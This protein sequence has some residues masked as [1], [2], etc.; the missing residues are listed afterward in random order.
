MFVGQ[1]DSKGI[2]WGTLRCLY[3]RPSPQEAAEGGGGPQANE[4]KFEASFFKAQWTERS[5][6]TNVVLLP[7]RNQGAEEAR[8]GRAF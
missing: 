5:Y 2:M 1:G 8:V 3:T 7:R 6:G 4:S